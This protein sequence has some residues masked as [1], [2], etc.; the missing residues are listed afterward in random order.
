MQET[1]PGPS[2]PS[3]DEY[4]IVFAED[5]PSPREAGLA[6]DDLV[7]GVV[8]G[9]RP[10]AYGINSLWEEDEHTLNDTLGGEPIAVSMCPLA[11]VAAA[12]SRRLGSETLEL[13]SLTT[14][15]QGSLV[16]YDRTSHSHYRLLTGEGFAGPRAG[17]RLARVPT[18]FTTW[19]RWLALHP[20]TT[21][22]LAPGPAGEHGLDAPRLRRLI[23]TG[24]GPAADRD[25]VV[26]VESGSSS[27]AFLV[28]SLVPRRIANDTLDGRPIVV[29]VSEDLATAVVWER[30]GRGRVLSFTAEHDQIRDAET[31]STWDP[32][33]GQAV[34]GPLAGQALTAV[35]S[36]S[37]FWHAWKAQHPET[38]IR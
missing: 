8:A 32:F 31:G 2:S 3:A 16:L 36:V 9:G 5:A 35:P 30:R 7:I 13:G 11:G 34:S 10:R 1:A 14:V 21:L 15:D 33:T 20:D 23:L 29:F 27:V 26:G 18:L 12:F 4:G 25:W 37:G 28:R 22:R 24:G 38:A 17:T 19:G 6:D